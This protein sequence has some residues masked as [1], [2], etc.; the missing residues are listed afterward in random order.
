MVGVTEG[1]EVESGA[2]E[3]AVEEAGPVLHSLEPG[4][5]Q[6]G[7]LAEVAFGQV[8][9]VGQGPLEV[10][11]DRLDRVELGG[12]WRQPLN[13]QP[14]PGGDQLGHRLAGVGVKSARS[15][16]PAFRPARFSGPLPAP[17]VPLSRHRALHMPRGRDG[18][19]PVLG[20][21]EGMREPR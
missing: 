13:G 9:Q 12:V 7:E 6:R 17:G 4:L 14:V 1:C 19:H 20:Q 15:A 10:R 18:P 11:P 5:D 21:G 3:E 16:V 2:G 8:G